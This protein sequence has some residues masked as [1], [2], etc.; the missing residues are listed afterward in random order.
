M[1][2]PRN[3]IVNYLDAFLQIDKIKDSSCNGL[4]VEGVKTVKRIG[5]AV[6]ACMAVYRKAAALGCQMILVHHGMIWNGLTNIRGA[7]K[8]QVKFLLG[9][10]INLYAAHLPLDM[11][12]DVGNNAVLA[13]RLGLGSVEPFGEYRG[14]RIGCRGVLPLPLSV[15]ELGRACKKIVGGGACTTLPFGRKKC[16]TVAIVS[17]G[18]SDAI[19]E[20]VERGIDCFVTGEPAHWNHHAAL[21]ARLNVLYLGHYHSETLG[22]KAV[23]KKLTKEFDAETVFIDEPTRV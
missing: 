11:H 4:Q 5:L 16:G 8:E 17:G 14:Y 23:G 1:S 18:G 20:A 13:R 10:G 15:A 2:I 21:E 3:K 9:K 6:D 7:L 12:Y 19:P 22:V